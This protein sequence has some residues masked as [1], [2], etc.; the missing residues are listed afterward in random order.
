MLTHLACACAYATSSWNET[1]GAAV[2]GTGFTYYET[3]QRH[4][5]ES[6][7]FLGRKQVTN[8]TRCWWWCPTARLRT[9]V[10]FIRLDCPS[11]NPALL[12][13]LVSTRTR[14]LSII[15]MLGVAYVADAF[16]NP[17][18][19]HTYTHTIFTKLCGKQSFSRL[20]IVLHC[21]LLT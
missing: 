11:L 15:S 13:I 17:V 8:V 9:V 3:L 4:F 21:L 16:P 18:Y 1:H 14:S 7:Y 10:L 6:M 2:N 20:N 19:T 5:T 12:L